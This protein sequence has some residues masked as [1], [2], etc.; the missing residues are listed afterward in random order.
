MEQLGQPRMKICKDVHPADVT[1]D[2][3]WSWSMARKYSAYQK[4]HS[5][6]T[7]VLKVL[8][9]ILLAVDSGISPS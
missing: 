5:T 9:D 1:D 4:H 8:G 3:L 6:E 7:A 2:S